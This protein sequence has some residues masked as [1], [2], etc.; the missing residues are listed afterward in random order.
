MRKEVKDGSLH[1]YWRYS[2]L[3]FDPY[4]RTRYTVSVSVDRLCTDRNRD[5]PKIKP[6]LIE[7]LIAGYSVLLTFCTLF[8]S[9][10]FLFVSF[11]KYLV[12][13]RTWSVPAFPSEAQT[14]CKYQRYRLWLK[15]SKYGYRIAIHQANC[16]NRNITCLS[17][18]SLICLSWDAMLRTCFLNNSSSKYSTETPSNVSSSSPFWS[19]NILWLLNMI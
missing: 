17:N 4:W 16:F 15:Q 13:W 2:R 1:V 11:G 5:T 9:V 10:V 14:I 3:T 12:P 6:R 18:G 19:E 7:E 8:A